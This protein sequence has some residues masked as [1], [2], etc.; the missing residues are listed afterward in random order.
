MI[1]IQSLT[2]ATTRQSWLNDWRLHQHQYKEQ[3]ANHHSSFIPNLLPELAVRLDVF[4]VLDILSKRIGTN[5][6]SQALNPYHSIPS[7]V[8]QQPDSQW[9]KSS[10]MVGVNVRTIGSFW[11]VVKYALT[12]P[13]SHDSIHLLPIWEPGVVGSLYGKVSWNINQEFFSHELTRAVP[14]LDTV[15]KQLKVVV[16]LL[17]AMGKSVGL[18]II[19]HTD[20]FSEIVIMH[21]R[22]FEWVRREGSKLTDHSENVWKDVEQAIWKWLRQNG[23]ADGSPLDFEPESLFNPSDSALTDGQRQSIL[24]GASWDQQLRLKRRIWL[25]QFLVY[26]GF[27]TLPMTMAPPYRGL[28]I[29]PKVFTVDERGTRWYQYDFDK[30]QAMSRVFGPLTRYRFFEPKDD[31]KNWELDFEKP[32]IAA[33][34]YFCRKYLECQ[35]QYNFDFMRGDMAHVQMQ[36]DGVPAQPTAFYDPLKAAKKYIQQKGTP[37]FA[38]YAETFLAPPDVMGYG[39]ELDHLEAIDADAT[40][41]DLQAAV[42]GSERFM[43]QFADYD[44]HL[45]TRQFAPS[46]TVITADKDDPRFDDF[47]RHGNLV[48]YFIALFLTDMPSYYSLGFEV[49]G[50]NIERNTNESYTKLY[51]FKINDDSEPD[52]VTHRPFQWGIN[53]THFD[54]LNRMRLFGESIWSQIKNKAI[55]WLLAPDRLAKSKLIVWTQSENPTYIFIVNL[56]ATEIETLPN[57]IWK[58]AKDYSVVY[59]SQLADNHTFS[60][61]ILP[62]RALVLKVN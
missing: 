38:F 49:R 60:T 2:V 9:L 4:Q 20:R 51:V 22:L 26:E 21:P 32:N 34:D 19:P 45:R 50:Q 42:V 57:A 11:N 18:D 62:E 37:H 52:K 47:Y 40:L 36:P 1:N 39:N 48:R 24:F 7:S 59:N 12:L 33:W 14:S 3:Y 13:E 8:V 44:N 55:R 17:H 30:P 58:M 35:Q 25:I 56:S 27:E 10:N 15:E 61:K 41:G 6:L 5:T 29:N 43:E 23:T 28:H 54:S 16:N 53:G 46:W 31:N